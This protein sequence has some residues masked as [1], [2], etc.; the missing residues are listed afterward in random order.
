MINADILLVLAEGE[1]SCVGWRNGIC[2]KAAG[3]G[4]KP[5]ITPMR[6]NRR[7]FKGMQVGD[8]IIGKAAALLLVLSG[9]EMVYGKIM[10]KAAVEVFVKHGVAY[11]YERLVD[12]IQNRQRDG[13][14]PLEQSVLDEDDPEVAWNKIE[15]K[16]EELMTGIE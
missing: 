1:Y 7:F 5:I 11:Q 8:T 2:Y 6:E 10:S 12:F 16:I 14:C 9:V 13:L 4:V 3:M 15:K